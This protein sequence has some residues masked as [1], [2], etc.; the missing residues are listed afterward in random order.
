MCVN[1][2]RLDPM[3]SDLDA[4][5]VKIARRIIPFMV[6]LFLMAW[7]D[8]YN[9]GFAKLQMVKDPASARRRTGSAALIGMILSEPAF[10]Q[11]SGT[12]LPCR[13]SMSRVRRAVAGGIALINSLGNLSGWAG[14]SIVGWLEDLTGKTSSGLCVVA[15][16][17][18]LAS[19]LI[20][21]FMPRSHIDREF[22]VGS[23]I[24]HLH[25]AWRSGLVRPGSHRIRFAFRPKCRFA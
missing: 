1:N 15:G 7:L 23:A 13:A 25:T 10:R 6:L 21:L 17:E 3:A 16:L 9:L 20:L 4:I 8:R 5:Y 12:P 14:P 19:A 18:V 2:A 24:S 22:S 11:Y